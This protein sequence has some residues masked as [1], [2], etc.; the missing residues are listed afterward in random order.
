MALKV[1]T[2]SKSAKGNSS[3]KLLPTHNALSPTTREAVVAALAP[4]LA[5][6]VDLHWQAKSAHWNVKGANFI[7]LHQL[8]DSVAEEVDGWADLIAER[9]VQLGGIA[10]GTVQVAA[11]KTVLSAY[12]L[13]IT[14]SPDH[15]AALSKALAAYGKLLRELIDTTGNLGDMDAADICT[16]VSRAADKMLWF[17]EAHG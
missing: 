5:S 2:N 14:A 3:P 17:V 10:R 16:E 1:R 9:I 7:G 11:S 12:P 6:S 8:F 13:A 4:A 15:V